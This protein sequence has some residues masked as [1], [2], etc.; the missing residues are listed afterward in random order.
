VKLPAGHSPASH[1]AAKPERKTQIPSV[2]S[3]ETFAQLRI[4]YPEA[5]YANPGVPK[6]IDVTL[7]DEQPNRSTHWLTAAEIKQRLHNF[8][9]RT[10]H[11]F[12][13]TYPLLLI[14]AIRDP[15]KRR[16]T[17]TADL[18]IISYPR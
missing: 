11:A 9:A 3:K 7:D 1:R 4:L 17:L 13:D 6:W 2:S 10:L 18:A 15:A 12:T 5:D 8:E 14:V 16:D